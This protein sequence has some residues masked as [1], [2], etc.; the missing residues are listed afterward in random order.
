[1]SNENYA[2]D[3][4]IIN[5]DQPKTD[6]AKVSELL[7]DDQYYRRKTNLKNREITLLA[8]LDSIAQLYGIS[9]FESW[10][11]NYCEYR[12]S[13]S[14]EARKQITEIAKY[15]I[16]RENNRIAQMGEFMSRR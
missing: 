4:D 6:L 12:T 5:V 11:P 10:I 3:E 16:D 8:T 14:G 15:S 7:L 9:F 13:E 2:I 1:M